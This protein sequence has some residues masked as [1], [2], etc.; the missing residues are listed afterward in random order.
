MQDKGNGVA[1]PAD[2]S[3]SAP[4]TTCFRLMAL[5]EE[6]CNEQVRH[7]AAA[8]VANGA[9]GAPMAYGLGR[10]SGYGPRT[11]RVEALDIEKEDRDPRKRQANRDKQTARAKRVRADREALDRLRKNAASS[12]HLL[13][14]A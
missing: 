1:V 6:F 13:D 10:A 3:D 8:W 7:A 14:R 4:W 5:D 9:R 2:W 11:W 12:A